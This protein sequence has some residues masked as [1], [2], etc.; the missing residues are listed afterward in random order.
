MTP[1]P[2]KFQEKGTEWLRSV[3]RGILGDAPGL[4]KTEQ[5]LAAAE[6][7]T[8][9]LVPAMAVETW[10]EEHQLW[11]PDLDLTLVPYSSLCEREADSRGR[12]TK[13]TSYPRSQWR[14]RWDTIICD[15]AHYLKGRSTFWTLATY[16]L[17][18]LAERL[19]MLTGTPVPNWSYEIFMLLRI[20]HPKDRRFTNF[21]DWVERW[22]KVWTPPWGSKEI[23]KLLPEFGWPEFIE[24]N[25]LDRDMLRRTPKSP[26]V[27][28]DL[29][30]LRHQIIEVDM[31]P[32]QAKA[33]TELKRDY[34][35]W[36]EETGT[37]VEAWKSDGA[38]HSKLEQCATGVD[39]LDPKIHCSPKLNLLSEL[40]AD[41]RGSATVVFVRHRATARRAME[42]CKQ[43]GLSAGMV[44]GD[45]ADAKRNV[46]RRQ[47]QAGNLEV[48]VG[49]L[50]TVKENW[51]LT[52]AN[53][54]IFVEHSWRPTTNHGAIKRLQRIGQ[55]HPVLAIHLFTRKTV[56]L[57]MLPVLRKKTS[58]QIKMMRAIEFARYLDG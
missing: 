6:G 49:T 25:S 32:R 48:L 46:V 33:Y 3:V 17:S 20:L 1:K 34:L 42:V 44:S 23:G 14:G 22:F 54:G 36:L 51:T 10:E 7:R 57:G 27:D 38:L 19:Y 2:Y 26:G 11:R 43:R 52:A 39:L 58:Q 56:D 18:K 13:P 53:T 45:V 31:L 50:D 8:L 37:W 24:G 4:G 28:L 12:L 15:E 30:P 29:P 55:K 5:A 35:T 9:G 47:F 21:W 41:R 40:L 16:K